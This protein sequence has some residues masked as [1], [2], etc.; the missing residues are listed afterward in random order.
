MMFWLLI[1]ATATWNTAVSAEGELL[2]TVP[3]KE[4]PMAV[5]MHDFAITENFYGFALTFQRRKRMRQER[6]NGVWRPL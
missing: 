4:L 5:M 6:I 2:R 1:R 3:M